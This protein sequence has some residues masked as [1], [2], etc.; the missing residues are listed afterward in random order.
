MEVLSRQPLKKKLENN[1]ASVHYF[2]SIKKQCLPYT[3][4][5]TESMLQSN[6]F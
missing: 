3:S 5:K 2:L 4:A 6:I 1:C